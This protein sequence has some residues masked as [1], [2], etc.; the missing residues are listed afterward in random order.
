MVQTASALFVDTNNTVYATAFGLRSVL[1][2]SVGGAIPTRTVFSDLNTTWSIAVTIRGDIYADNGNFN[3]RIGKC[4]SNESNS[5]AAI[6]VSGRCSG[7]FVDLYDNLYCSLTDY[8]RIIRRPIDT[9]DNTSAIVA[10]TG[11]FGSTPDT[12]WNPFGIFVDTDLSFYV[13][14]F[15][16]QRI[17][18]FRSN[19]LNGTTVAGNG[20]PNTVTLF[21]PTG[22]TL[23]GDGFLYISDNSLHQI[24]GSGP[25]GF[26]CIAGCTGTS[27]SAANQL[28]NPYDLSFDSYGNLY[29]TDA[30]NH[31]IQKFLLATNS[32]SKSFELVF[33]AHV[34]RD[35]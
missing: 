16:N 19:Q 11:S 15:S 14:D 32:C 21:H 35:T 25:N 7:L 29:V 26:R 2:W 12:L 8:H 33:L 30:T 23:D 3:H 5:T 27:G 28:M 13:A 17:Q 1:V 18:L 31:R 4:S 9:F 24:V 10:G 6:Y 20:A 22:V 34:Y